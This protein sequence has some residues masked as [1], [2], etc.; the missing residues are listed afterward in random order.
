MAAGVGGFMGAGVGGGGPDFTSL[1]N[2]INVLNQSVVTLTQALEQS[3]VATAQQAAPVAAAAQQAAAAA[4]QQAAPVA[5]AAQQ[6]TAA[7]AQQQTAAAAP[8]AASTPTSPVGSIDDK[9]NE[10]F[11]AGRAAGISEALNQA[12]TIDPSLGEKMEY[13]MEEEEE[14]RARQA[15]ELARQQA[16]R[17]RLDARIFPDPSVLWDALSP[18]T[19]EGLTNIAETSAKLAKIGLGWDEGDAIHN[20]AGGATG[21][22]SS[23]AMLAGPAVVKLAGAAAI[24]AGINEQTRTPRGGGI[25]DADRARASAQASAYH[26]G[27]V[28][29]GAAQM[30]Y[31]LGSFIGSVAGIGQMASA[32]ARVF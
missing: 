29:R 14:E 22:V 15:E 23:A 30:T 11:E 19:Q 7:A 25:V 21:M 8:L 9:L 4:A 24:M 12:S 20:L 1:E 16:R 28:Q 6:Q 13:T 17:I 10:A 32:N 31:S 2:N 26:G 5:A 3:P 27:G 18:G